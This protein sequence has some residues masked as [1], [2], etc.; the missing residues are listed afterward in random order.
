V[1]GEME[2]RLGILGFGWADT[3]ASQVYTVFDLY[4]FRGVG[5]NRCNSW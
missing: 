1:L 3:T 5:V 2:R 4:P